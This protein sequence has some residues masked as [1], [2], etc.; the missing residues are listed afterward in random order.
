MGVPVPDGSPAPGAVRVGLF[1][2]IG[3]SETFWWPPDCCRRRDREN[4]VEL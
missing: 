3:K 4:E 2:M 1:S